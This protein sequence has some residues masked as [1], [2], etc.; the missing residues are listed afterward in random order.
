M[1]CDY[2]SSQYRECEAVGHMRL[3]SRS[4]DEIRCS[5]SCQPGTPAQ[6][7]CCPHPG[8]GLPS[9][10]KPSLASPSHTCPEVCVSWA[11]LSSTE[12]M[13]A[14][15]HCTAWL[16]VPISH[17]K[18]IH[19]K[20]ANQQSTKKS[21]GGLTRTTLT[22]QVTQAWLFLL[23]HCPESDRMKAHSEHA[24]SRDACGF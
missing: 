18:K 10:I 12:L 3:H 7:C 11:T 4:R 16:E 22:C 23:L 13:M 5:P 15:K 14:I 24:G 19:R 9:T 17:I 6:G 21:M 8:W 1:V 20:S 2:S